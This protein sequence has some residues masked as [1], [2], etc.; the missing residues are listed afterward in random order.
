MKKGSFL[1]VSA[2]WF[3]IAF[4]A[5]NM[6]DGINSSSSHAVTQD[7]LSATDYLWIFQAVFIGGF[8]FA[9]IFLVLFIKEESKLPSLKLGDII[10]EWVFRNGHF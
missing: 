1:I 7:I 6:V 5:M 3:L 10:R 2:I 4:K 8:I 9:I